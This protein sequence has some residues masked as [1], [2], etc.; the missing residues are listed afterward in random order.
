MRYRP[1]VVFLH[2]VLGQRDYHYPECSFTASLDVNPP[3]GHP[4]KLRFHATF[5][6]DV[7][8]V[9]KLLEEHKAV[10]AVWIYCRHTSYRRLFQAEPGKRKLQG[11]IFTDEVYG[12][13]EFHPAIFSRTDLDLPLDQANKAFGVANRR[14]LA[15]S[16]L[17]VDSEPIGYTIEGTSTESTRSIFQLDK[18]QDMPDGVWKSEIDV[19]ES[20]IYLVASPETLIS[21]QR[22]R[23]DQLTLQTLYLAALVEALGEY[24]RAYESESWEANENEELWV[25]AITRQLNK[26]KITVIGDG[27][28]DM[29]NH[30]RT[31]PILWVAQRLLNDPLT[32]IGTES[33][34]DG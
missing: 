22:I 25:G 3:T 23:D 18:N 29:A 30:G 8:G 16:P 1:D 6:C 24:L 13:I 33:S 34:G 21:F 9:N 20:V 31:V 5:D 12:Q 11:S 27:F 28:S 15:G 7:D 2:P 17:A 19:S 10:C 4:R 26:H 32:G 14:I